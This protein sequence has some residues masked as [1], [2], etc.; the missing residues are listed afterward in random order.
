MRA[1][2]QRNPA[3]RGYV[4]EPEQAAPLAG[5]KVRCPAHR[6]QGGGYGMA[7]LPLL[8]GI[9]VDGFLAVS[10]EEAME[11]AARLAR[12]EGIFGGFSSGAN[13]AAALKLLQGPERGG[14]IVI[15]ICDTGL[16]YL[17]TELWRRGP[18]R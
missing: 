7:E 9:A 2:K 17:S 1:F 5:H 14:T 13:L 16:K 15:M 12:E 18:S 10:D 3:I 8:A 6:I 11:A 4:V